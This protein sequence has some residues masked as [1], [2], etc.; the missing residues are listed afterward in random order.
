MPTCGNCGEYVTYTF[1]RVFGAD[2]AIHGC[3]G[4]PS[5]TTYRELYDG[6]AVVSWSETL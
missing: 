5:C 4:C 3:R 1:A 2:G 6:E